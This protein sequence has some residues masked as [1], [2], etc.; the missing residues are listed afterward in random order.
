MPR[1]TEETMDKQ[2]ALGKVEE[3][4]SQLL[5]AVDGLDEAAMSERFY[6]D[7][8]AKDVLAHIAG[9]H[10]TMTEG[11]ERMARGE[12]PTPE[13]VDYSD[14]DSWNAKFAAAMKPQNASTV[15]AT[16]RQ[17]FMNFVRAARAIPD[18][19]YGEGKTINRILEASGYGH[20]DEHLPA[21]QEL[22]SRHAAAR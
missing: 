4:F 6:G 2:T 15:V 17:S 16:L 1:A 14:A 12:R 22:K 8:A 11:M 5:G 10:Q 3:G 7:W 19:R 13:G 9:W 18:D 21:L 20:Y